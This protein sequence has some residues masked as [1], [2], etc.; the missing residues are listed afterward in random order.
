MICWSV[1][2]DIRCTA[3]ETTPVCESSMLCFCKSLFSAKTISTS[4]WE[5]VKAL[6]EIRLSK[7]LQNSCV[8]AAE[9]HTR[10]KHRRL[11]TTADH[12]ML[13]SLISNGIYIWKPG[14]TIR[15]SNVTFCKIQF[16]PVISLLNLVICS[17]EVT[18]LHG[19]YVDLIWKDDEATASFS[20]LS[21]ENR[22]P[23]SAPRSRVYNKLRQD[24]LFV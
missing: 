2:V 9:R 13:N 7:E 18:L 24:A 8:V 10:A 15:Y 22:S 23:R 19:R 16:E 12:E 4:H 5:Q 11:Y 21:Q 6:Q 17:A 14:R 3:A 1:G 20:K